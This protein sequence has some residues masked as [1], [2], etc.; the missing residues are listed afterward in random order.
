MP[1]K[2]IHTP[3]GELSTSGELRVS[4]EY[5]W[6]GCSPIYSVLDLFEI[7]TPNGIVYFDTGKPKLFYPSLTHDW[8]CQFRHLLYRA[9]ITDAMID[10][11]FIVQMERVAFALREAYYYVVVVARMIKVAFFGYHKEVLQD[12]DQVVVTD[13]SV[14][15]SQQDICIASAS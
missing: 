8:C 4:A 1:T 5:A 2:N 9:G 10:R 7:G 11:E 6:N 3:W 13:T 14:V 12:R 15:Y